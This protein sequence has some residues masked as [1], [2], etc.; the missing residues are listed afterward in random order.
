MDNELDKLIEEIIS[1]S[2]QIA[3]DHECGFCMR[4]K[5]CN[6]ICK[7]AFELQVELNSRINDAYLQF[8]RGINNGEQRESHS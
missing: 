5:E 7:D 4:N 2:C 1:L 8:K 3:R 6:K